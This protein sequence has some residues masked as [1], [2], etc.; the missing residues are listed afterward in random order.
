MIPSVSQIIARRLRVT[1][2]VVGW[3]GGGVFRVFPFFPSLEF[4]CGRSLDRRSPI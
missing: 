1:G 4:R 2:L 3:G